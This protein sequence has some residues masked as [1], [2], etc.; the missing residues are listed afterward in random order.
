MQDTVRRILTARVYD[1]AEETPLDPLKRLSARIGRPALL[2]REDLQ[3]V[4]SFKIRGAYNRI[5]NLSEAELARGVICAS[6]GNHAQGVALAAAR[7]GAAST[8]V[9]P[10]TTP[11]IKVAAVKGLGGTV[12][13]H[14]D[15]FDDAYAH[16]RHL[17]Q[18]TGATFVHPFDDPDVIAGQGTVGLEIL[19]QHP[20]PVDAVFV[21]IGGGGLAAGVAAIVRFLRPET[22][23]IGVEPADA[24]T[25][26]SAIDAG[27]VVT[28]DQVGLFADGV[29]V[30]RAGDE[31]FRLCRDLL[32]EIVLVDTDAI[33]A[34]VKDIFDD[35]R[36][37]AEPS[38]AVALAGLKIWAAR[39][40]GTG[41][42]VAV[43]SGA[44]V[45]F[46]R[47][48][49]VAERAEI[50][51]GAEALLAVAMPD[52]RDDYHRFLQSLDGRSVTEF[53][54]R[55][56]GDGTAQIFVGVSLKG[57]GAL[58]QPSAA[59]EAI[60][61]EKE[62]LIER[63]RADG[64]AV[65]DM[66]DNETAKL[67]VRYMVGG[68]TIGLPHERLLRFEF[69]ERPGA[70]LRFLNSLQPAWALTLFHYRNHGDD[71]GRVLAGVSIAPDQVAALWTALDALGYPYVDETD[72]PAC[73]LFLDG[74]A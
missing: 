1:V 21:P 20:D 25:M 46:D 47:L 10:T 72:N 58:K 30:R 23:I 36:A 64:Y 45:N 13:L 14:G 44:N 73:R 9:M 26:K 52:R 68:R 51:E 71:V 4:F 18:E 31:T 32:D 38:G 59:R 17:E 12:V 22:K 11:G 16:A 49:H 8:I 54:Y 34:A 28:L 53:N 65:E 24:P 67:H 19:R 27:Q 7:R 5:A 37:V 40:P 50:G 33:C 55:W 66:S 74:A 6:A 56:S 57:G 35:V 29:A 69:P 70:F 48:R 3:P 15:S 2:K 39:H 41:A 60:G 61:Q 42:L 63:L 62:D 43:N